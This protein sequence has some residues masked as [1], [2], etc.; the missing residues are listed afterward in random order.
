MS[1]A[2]SSSIT[3][4]G[5]VRS[6]N[7]LCFAVVLSAFANSLA[8]GG[9]ESPMHFCLVM[10]P[11]LSMLLIGW[12]ASIV[13]SGIV[14]V[15][16]TVIY[17]Q[18]WVGL[19]ATPLPRQQ[20]LLAF[21]CLEVTVVIGMVSL[22]F[23]YRR[24][25]ELLLKIKETQAS[26]LERAIQRKKDFLAHVA[27]EIRTPLHGLLALTGL[28]A[29]EST[30]PADWLAQLSKVHACGDMLLCLVNNVLDLSAI[31]AGVLRVEPK[32]TPLRPLLGRCFELLSTLAA[33]KSP[34]IVCRL[35]VDTTVPEAAVLDELRLT[36]ALVSAFFRC[37]AQL[38]TLQVNLAGNAVKFTETGSIDMSLSM[39]KGELV[40][41]VQDT[42]V[43]LA[44]SI[45]AS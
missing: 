10:V 6:A 22:T 15:S 19:A 8:T 38:G 25:L 30:P 17:M 33:Q 20:R 40:F 13:W 44:T 32:P 31:E 18:E 24:M 14:L 5:A 39:D 11:M 1:C 23:I 26:E 45:D 16:I 4:Q 37:F 28:L 43:G 29:S 36:Q 35:T 42:G 21:W 7:V 34:T 9:W 3:P 2:L 12:N 27:H 41:Q